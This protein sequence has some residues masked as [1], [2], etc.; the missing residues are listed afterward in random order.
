MFHK[1]VFMPENIFVIG[2]C[3]DPAPAGKGSPSCLYKIFRRIIINHF[4]TLLQLSPIV[5]CSP[6]SDVPSEFPRM[7]G[8]SL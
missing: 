2:A 1:S 6:E 4:K 7:I 3:P 8:C 5:H